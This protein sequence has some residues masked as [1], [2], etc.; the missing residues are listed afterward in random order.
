MTVATLQKKTVSI[1]SKRQFTI[2]QAFY[3]LLNFRDKAECEVRG[4]E[5]IIRPSIEPSGSEFAEKILEDLVAE[6]LSGKELLT[7]FK[8]R[9]FQVRPAV[10]RMLSDAAKVAEG[11]AQY[12]TIS[13]IFGEDDTNA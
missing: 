9:Q 11:N 2:P 7:E 12:A 8:R 5:L 6:G 3:K 10:Q 4:N 1:S 13:D